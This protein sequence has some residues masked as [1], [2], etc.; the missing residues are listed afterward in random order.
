MINKIIW[1]YNII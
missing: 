1:N